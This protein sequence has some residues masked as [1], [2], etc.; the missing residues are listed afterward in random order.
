ML[1]RPSREGRAPSGSRCRRRHAAPQPRKADPASPTPPRSSAESAPT[2]PTTTGKP[3]AFFPDPARDF[4]PLRGPRILHEHITE[5]STCQTRIPP[6]PPI[7]RPAPGEYL[8]FR[9]GAG[10]TV[11]DI[12]KGR[13]PLLRIAD[14]HR[15]CAVKVHKFVFNLRGVSVPIVDLRLNAAAKPREYTVSSRRDRLN[16]GAAEW[17]RRGGWFGLRRARTHPRDDQA[18]AR[19][20]LLVGTTSSPASADVSDRSEPYGHRG[21]ALDEQRRMGLIDQP[22]TEPE[23]REIESCGHRVRRQSPV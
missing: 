14:A 17:V 23:Y 11:I 20:R 1:T 15:Q 7:S 18:G 9:L 8:T 19:A 5:G 13:N 6:A 12:L 16:V 2:P 4:S 22:R 21:E 3:S 10:I